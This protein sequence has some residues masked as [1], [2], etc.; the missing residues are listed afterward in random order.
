MKGGEKGDLP[1]RN[2]AVECTKCWTHNQNGN[3]AD[4][5]WLSLLLVRTGDC[6][7]RYLPNDN[8]VKLTMGSGSRSSFPLEVPYLDV[9]TVEGSGIQ[10]P[11]VPLL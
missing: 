8:C 7:S 4:G 11:K 9:G 3:G 10:V 2:D 1:L 6:S 5:G